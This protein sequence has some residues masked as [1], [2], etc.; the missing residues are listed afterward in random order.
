MNTKA[1]KVTVFDEMTR[2]M[3]Q[4]NDIMANVKPM[5]TVGTGKG[6]KTVTGSA[7]VPISLCYI[8]DR[9]QGRD[10]FKKKEEYTGIQKNHSEGLDN[11]ACNYSEKHQR[12]H[13]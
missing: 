1:A 5:Q 4:F 12:T 11:E 10:Y 8:D 3:E 7:V 13:S 6:M 9:Y 2:R